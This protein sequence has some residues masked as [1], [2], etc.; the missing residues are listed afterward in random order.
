MFLLFLSVLSSVIFQILDTVFACSDI[1]DQQS[2]VNE[3]L[4]T[5]KDGTNSTKVFHI[6]LVSNWIKIRLSLIVRVNVVWI[7]LFLLTVTDISTTCEVVIFFY[8]EDDYRTG[9]WNV[10]HC[11]QQQSYSGLHS[12]GRSNSNYFWNDSWVQTF[13]NIESTCEFHAICL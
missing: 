3:S 4:N 2:I 6:Y 12:P 5:T 11:Q 7:G 8:S 1:H 10:S 9:C 13:H